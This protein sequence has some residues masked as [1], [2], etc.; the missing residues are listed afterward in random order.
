MEKKISDRQ[1]KMNQLKLD[2]WEKLWQEV[3]S[4]K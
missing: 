2:D 1:I 3:K 4:E